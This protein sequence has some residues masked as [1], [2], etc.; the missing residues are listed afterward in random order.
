MCVF[1]CIF[2]V[3][4][5]GVV[6]LFSFFFFSNT[7]DNNNGPQSIT[8]FRVTRT[9]DHINECNS[10][11]FVFDVAGAAYFLI[12]ILLNFFLAFFFFVHHSLNLR[13]IQCDA[14]IEETHPFHSSCLRCYLRLWIRARRSSVFFSSVDI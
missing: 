8:V 9:C 14:L 10:V 11:Y 5:S 2:T 12:L 7:W 6:R 13:A 4:F 1:A 3:Y